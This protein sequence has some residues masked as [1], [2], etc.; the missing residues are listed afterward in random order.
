MLAC[1]QLSSDWEIGCENLKFKTIEEFEQYRLTGFQTS[2]YQKW[3]T[4]EYSALK[5]VCHRSG[6]E[7][8]LEGPRLRYKRKAGS[9]KLGGYCPMEIVVRV[10]RKD[11]TC[12]VTLQRT[13][14]GHNV[15]SKEEL[16]YQ[17]KLNLARNRAQK[18]HSSVSEEI[19][20]NCYDIETEVTLAPL[21]EDAANVQTFVNENACVFVC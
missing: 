21:K 10:N 6:D 3:S 4:N 9:K 16:R 19:L 5:Y 18:E 20:T 14:V 2:V 1:I 17:K 8:H 12:N 15:H 13:H 7:D 11:G